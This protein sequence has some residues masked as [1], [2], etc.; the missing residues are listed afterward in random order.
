MFDSNKKMSTVDEVAELAVVGGGIFEDAPRL[1]LTLDRTFTGGD[2]S[3]KSTTVSWDWDISFALRLVV[4]MT[5]TAPFLLLYYF[6]RYTNKPK[7]SNKC[8]NT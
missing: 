4:T 1:A 6:T 8:C 3:I 7:F 2:G 5:K